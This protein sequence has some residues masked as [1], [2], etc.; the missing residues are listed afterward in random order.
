MKILNVKLCIII[1]HD[2]SEFTHAQ[3]HGKLRT[4]QQSV[5]SQKPSLAAAMIPLATLHL[6]VLV[7]H[8]ANEEEIE[9]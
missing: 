1:D 3:V 4:V 8:R 5:E 2:A 7:M 6:T 9:R